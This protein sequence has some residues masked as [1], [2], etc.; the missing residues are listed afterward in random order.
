MG[1]NTQFLTSFTLFLRERSIIEGVIGG[2]E[3]IK[4]E[5]GG[6]RASLSLEMNLLFLL[7]SHLAKYVGRDGERGIKIVEEFH[8][9]LVNGWNYVVHLNGLLLPPNNI[10]T[11]S[12]SMGEHNHPSRGML[13]KEVH[14]SVR[15][16]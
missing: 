9:D 15:L 14:H 6:K 10:E 7:L 13:L 8:R 1:E 11:K 5:E 4:H 16:R 12:E 3:S 2:R